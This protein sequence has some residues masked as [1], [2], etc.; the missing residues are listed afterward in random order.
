[1]RQPLLSW[2][3]NFAQSSFDQI[4]TSSL[5]ATALVDRL[6]HHA[7][8]IETSGES[9]RRARTLAGKGEVLLQP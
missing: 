5:L 1:M 9:I 8:I 6:A 3:S 2:T 4:L 7:H